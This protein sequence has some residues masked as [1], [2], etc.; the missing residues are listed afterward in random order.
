MVIFNEL[1][2]LLFTSNACLMHLFKRCSRSETLVFGPEEG[3][4][5]RKISITSRKMLSTSLR[6]ALAP[7][8]ADFFQQERLLSKR[9]LLPYILFEG[10][11]KILRCYKHCQRSIQPKCFL[12]YI[13]C[14]T[15]LQ[16]KP[17]VC[18]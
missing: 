16:G 15:I 5:N 8:S 2:P 9:S 6:C 13:F 3:S 17:L 10:I 4:S 14:Q 11:T 7:I 18:A 12:G 1:L